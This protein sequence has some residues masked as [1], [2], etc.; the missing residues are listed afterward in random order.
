MQRRD[1]LKSALIL[2]G[3]PL[4]IPALRPAPASAQ[5]ARESRG[6]D[7]AWLKN[8]ARRRSCSSYQ[9]PK[10][11]LPKALAKLDYDDYQSIRFDR[12]RSL[13]ADDGLPVTG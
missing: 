12:D 2:A 1:F 10:V 6:F 11:S 7:Y 5:P 13:W 9:A 8:Q 3:A 4:S